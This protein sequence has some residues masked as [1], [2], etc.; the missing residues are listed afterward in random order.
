MSTDR[1]GR[2]H[3]EVARLEFQFACYRWLFITD[4]ATGSTG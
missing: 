2:V 1:Q 3:R 4:N